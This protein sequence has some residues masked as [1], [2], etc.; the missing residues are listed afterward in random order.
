MNTRTIVLVVALA[1]LVGL[2]A[3]F[4]SG[5]FGGGDAIPIVVV[6]RPARTS[7]SSPDAV[8]VVFGLDRDYKFASIKVIAEGDD[9]PLWHLVSDGKEWTDKNPQHGSARSFFYGENIRGMKPAV[10]GAKPGAIEPGTKYRLIVEAEGWVE[11]KINAETKEK[12]WNFVS[13]ERTGELDFSPQA[14]ATAQR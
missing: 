12:T 5:L 14:K 7:Q 9:E 6:P 11:L 10:E 1:V 4:F 2:W 13:R 8:P 3:I